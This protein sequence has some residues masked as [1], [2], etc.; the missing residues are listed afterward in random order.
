MGKF[1]PSI[2]CL[3]SSKIIPNELVQDQKAMRQKSSGTTRLDH[4]L[5]PMG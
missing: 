4:K 2:I 3:P 1:S 5:F